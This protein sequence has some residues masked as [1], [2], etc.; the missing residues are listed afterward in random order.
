[1]LPAEQVFWSI[2]LIS[3]GLFAIYLVFQFAG[4]HDHDIHP[5]DADPGF[6]V[7]SLRSI[8]A[9]GMFMGYTGVAAMHLGVGWIAALIAGLVAGVVAAWLAWRLLQLILRL[10]SSGTLDLHQAVGLTGEVYIPVPAARQGTGKVMV[11]VQGALR[12][13]EAISEG[14]AIPTGAPVLV[15]AVTDLG[16]LIVQ[17]FQQHP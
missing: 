15:V 2:G 12:E 17:P 14:A 9:F 1:M 5:D 4:G 8:L 16:V 7:L 11:A 6:T 13:L 10:Q 3:N